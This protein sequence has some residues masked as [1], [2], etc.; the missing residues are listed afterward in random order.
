[1]TDTI[2]TAPAAT[3]TAPATAPATAPGAAPATAPATAAAPDWAKDW[4]VAPEVGEWLGKAGYKTPADFA[5]SA[6]ATKK[7]VG[8]DP[9]SIIVAPKEGD[10]AARLAAL[11]KLGAPEKAEDYGFKAPEGGDAKLVEWFGKTAAEL[12]IPKAE[13]AGLFDRWNAYVGEQVAGQAEA[14]EAARAAQFAE[15][16]AK[17]GANYGR[18]EQE[19]RA[20]MREAGLTGEQG[21]ALEQALGIEGATMMMA[22][23][24][25][26]FVETAFKGGDGAGG[27]FAVTLEQAQAQLAALRADKA[28]VT[29]FSNGDVD[30]RKQIAALTEMIAN[31]TPTVATANATPMTAKGNAPAGRQ[32]LAAM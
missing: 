11:R 18:I 14:Q 31:L 9:A 15:F 7:L 8:H 20:A 29:R 2:L 30:A 5:S 25:K 6:M 32:G 24:G 13:A 19:A 10:S 12:G 22:K 21:I 28:F 4:N 16:K 1:M 27:S 26:H 3:T 17:A 23:L